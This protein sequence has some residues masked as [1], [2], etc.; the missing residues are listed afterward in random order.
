MSIMI[1]GL[2][3][4][5]QRGGIPRPIGNSPE[6]L[7]QAIS[8]G[9]MSVGRLGVYCISSLIIIMIIIILVIII[10]IIISSSSSSSNNVGTNNVNNNNSTWRS[11]APESAMWRSA[12]APG[13]EWR[14]R[15][16]ALQRNAEN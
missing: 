15:S 11:C 5:I 9:I 1:G 14:C 3:I 10:R 12:G 13:D 4:L 2:C 6:S 16:T 7:S 8:V